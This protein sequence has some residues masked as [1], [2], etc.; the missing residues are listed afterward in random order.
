MNVL[1]FVMYM[2]R[3]KTVLSSYYGLCSNLATVVLDLFSHCRETRSFLRIVSEHLGKRML[4]PMSLSLEEREPAEPRGQI[5]CLGGG[6]VD[7][8]A[9]A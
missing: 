2:Q 5:S 4:L 8:R 6:N 7:P 1:G 3:L 9:E